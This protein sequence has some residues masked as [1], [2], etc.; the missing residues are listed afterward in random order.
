MDA[1]PAVLS[2]TPTAAGLSSALCTATVVGQA[3]RWLFLDSDISRALRAESCLLQ[4]EVG[5]LVLLCTGL[6]AVSTASAGVAATTVP[7]VLAVLSRARLG[8]SMVTLPGGAA[9]GTS[10]GALT[11][12]AR[13]ITLDAAE[14]MHTRTR[15]FNVES[16]DAEV[17]FHT[18]KTRI[19][20]LDAGIGRLTLVARSVAS[21]VGRLVQR[22]TESIRW[23][24]TTDEL[25][26]G[27]ARWRITGHAHMHTQHTTMQSEE[28]TRIDGSR[29]ELG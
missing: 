6:P 11:L 12:N 10:D 16:M 18:V 9:I 23:I 13:H 8:A 21:T 5:D 19:S 7:Y 14:G 24:D 22:A 2:A 20:T 4:P 28:V 17:T 26:A 15:S 29:I 27:S 3:D 1:K 25:R